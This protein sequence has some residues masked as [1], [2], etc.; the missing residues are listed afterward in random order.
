VE[1]TLPTTT[2]LDDLQLFIRQQEQLDQHL[3]SFGAGTDVSNKDCNRIIFEDVDKAPSEVTL[4]K[5]DHGDPQQQIHDFQARGAT[6]VLFTTVFDSGNKVDVVS[7][8][9][10]LA[11]AAAADITNPATLLPA[12]NVLNWRTKPEM[13]AYHG[14]LPDSFKLVDGTP[15][16]PSGAVRYESKFDIDADGSGPKTP[17]DTFLPDTSLHDAKNKAFN[18]NEYPF[19]VIPG[20]PNSGPSVQQVG[21]LSLGDIGIAF[22]NGKSAAF[23]YGDSGPAFEIGEG[24]VDL[25]N[26]LGI[27]SNP[28]KGGMQKIPPGVIHIA[29]PGSRDL[30][31]GKGKTS[32]TK[33]D[34]DKRS[35]HL[36]SAFIAAHKPQVG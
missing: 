18:A 3:K 24:S 30:T 23:L 11:P 4:A 32:F 27:P 7:F 21:G 31:A 25:A 22:F 12:I 8:R 14:L 13:N 26:S 10:T 33:D 15:H 28:V 36:L 5:L 34:L 19:A 6:D 29:F 35:K 2:K 16:F 1:F 9:G 17:G 20:I